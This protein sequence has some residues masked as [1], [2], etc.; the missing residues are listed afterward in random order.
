MSRVVLRGGK[1]ELDSPAKRTVA[2][3]CMSRAA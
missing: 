1:F 2:G 3:H